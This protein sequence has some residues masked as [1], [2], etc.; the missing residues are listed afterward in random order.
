MVV[1][2]ALPEY[3]RAGGAFV[4]SAIDALA[5]VKSPLLAEIGS[6]TADPTPG[7]RTTFAS[8]EVLEHEPMRIGAT[9][10]IPV[11]AAVN[12]EYEGFCAA[13]DDAAEEYASDL[14]RQIYQRLGEMSEAAGT[15]VSAKDPFTARDVL[16]MIERLEIEFD[17]QGNPELPKIHMHPSQA[18][19]LPSW[20]DADEQAF[21]ELMVRKKAEWDARRRH[22]RLPRQPD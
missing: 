21:K 20:T 4:R 22:R 19:K 17:E 10:S 15:S 16:T 9:I 2:F 8:G 18:E 6:E 14:S 7:V 3:E 13:I 11:R 12:G 5:R 1:V